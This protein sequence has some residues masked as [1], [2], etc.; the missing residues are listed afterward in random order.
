MKKQKILLYG[1]GTFK[2]KGCE[3]LVNSTINQIENNARIVA[4]SFDY[5]NDKNMYKEK[6]EKFVDH[7]KH[8]EQKF[9]KKEL[10][11]FNRLQTK[12]WNTYDYECFYERDV[13]NEM[14]DADMCIHIGGDN[15]CY[16]VNE[17]M[18]AI[19]K[20]AR[21]LGKKN[22]LW[23][24]SLYD[25]I[26]DVDL[27]EDLKRYDLLILREKISYNAIKKYVSEDKLMLIPDPAFSLKPKSIQLN[28]WYEKG[29][30]IGL[31]LSPLTIKN[32]EQYESIKS[33]ID[34]I[35]NKTKYKILLLPHVTVEE[36]SDLIILRRIA[37]DYKDNDRIYLEEKDYNCQE[38]K[39]IISK[40]H[41]I[42][43]SRTHASI[44]AYSSC[45]PTLVIGY[46]VKSRGIAEDIFGNYEKYVLPANKISKQSIIS[47]FEYILDN[48]QKIK[49]YLSDKMPSI[50]EQSSKIYENMLKKLK[51]Q[52][53]KKICSHECCTGCCTCYNICPVNAIEIKENKEGFNYPIIND[54]KCINCGLCKKTCP[55]LNKRKVATSKIDCYVAKSKNSDLLTKS[56]SGGIFTHLALEILNN[57]GVIYG[58]TMIDF[59]VKH[60]RIAK[61]EDLSK[62][63]G[64]KYSES[65]LGKIYQKVK[66]DLDNDI[67][68]L[69]SGTPCQILGL[70]KY[71]QKKY[72]N[73]TTISVI[74]HGVINYNLLKKRISEFE[75]IFE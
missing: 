44:A 64:S 53:N 49:K 15:Y 23:G 74:C 66:K 62:I 18:Y 68:V 46:S 56:S 28:K 8:D 14:K 75:N 9:D 38:L 21:E 69:F 43:A 59:K 65:W 70:K 54:E 34:Y 17:W 41:I 60:I 67:D 27:I 12:K 32:D 52:E 16:G 6:I 30:I 35:L 40:C 2:N 33:L 25:E 58:A 72:K 55:I 3:A 47:S 57:S 45:V 24:A 19:T 39:Y 13:I 73:L 1:V 29:N 50:I 11:E 61:K 4:A 20:K 37:N 26:K 71:L 42:V 7:H 51:Y 10:E 5:K 63:R 31:N 36:A 22:I 48:K